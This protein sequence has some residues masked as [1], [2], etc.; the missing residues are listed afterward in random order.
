MKVTEV[1]INPLR[2]G[3]KDNEKLRAFA[4]ITF[5]HCFVVR[6]VKVIEG[7]RGLFV[8]MPSRKQMERCR[9]CGCRN[10]VQSNFCNGCGAKLPKQSYRDPRSREK[11]YLDIAHPVNSECRRMVHEAVIAAYEEECGGDAEEEADEALEESGVES[12]VE[13]VASE[14]EPEPVMACAE[15]EDTGE[16]PEVESEEGFNAGIFA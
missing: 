1:R 14:S 4:T 13:E 5:D 10:A 15:V 6:E 12:S 3:G 2:D 16:E 7:D 8:A 11:V 9:Q